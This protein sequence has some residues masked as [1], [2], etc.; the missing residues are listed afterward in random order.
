MVAVGQAV[1]Y[2]EADW[3]VYDNV[4]SL[5][6]WTPIRKPSG[7]FSKIRKI[8]PSNTYWGCQFVMWHETDMPYVCAR[9]SSLA[10]LYWASSLGATEIDVYGMDMDGNE[11]KH[12]ND[13]RWIEE[14]PWAQMTAE[15]LAKASIK[16]EWHGAFNPV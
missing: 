12:R 5:A 1:E 2:V 13:E 6:H 4:R 3:M 15:Y 7:L 16:V 11:D 14:I 8:D 10:A 9:R